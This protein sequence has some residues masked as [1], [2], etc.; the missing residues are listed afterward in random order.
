[1]ARTKPLVPLYLVDASIY[2]F[3]AY[4]SLPE[5][6]RN[7][8]GKP[9]NA[10]Y[11]FAS[12]LSGLVSSKKPQHIAAMF[13]ESLDTCFRNTLYPPYK[14]SRALPD[15]DLA[16]QLNWCRELTELVGIKT[17]ASNKYEADDL[18][19][20]TAARM[21]DQGF[22]MIY[23]TGD[24]DLGQL[25][26]GQDRIWDFARDEL[27]GRRDIFN[28][29]GIQPH[30]FADYLGL[31]GDAVDDIPGVPGIGV[32]TASQLISRF[33][34]LAT[35]YDTLESGRFAKTNN[36]ELRGLPRIESLL[37]QHKEQAW[38]S[39]ELA[40]ISETANIRP[41]PATIRRK[42]VKTRSLKAWLAKNGFGNRL[43]S[44]LP[45]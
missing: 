44:R 1:M 42:P 26:Q 14:A 33:G 38:L 22:R 16:R 31:A 43:A 17:Y 19:G 37:T 3:R 36:L 40:T 5:S 11:G 28:R 29:F 15:T 23:V 34:D 24:K 9:A 20:T 2:I 25:I 27:Y 45:D 8:Q 10:V 41:T 12:F 32:K 18:I 6:I 35:L 39:R 21:R 4:F 7:N 30:Q 13:D